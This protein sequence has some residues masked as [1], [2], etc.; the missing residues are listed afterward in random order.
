[1]KIYIVMIKGH[2]S[3][4]CGIPRHFKNKEKNIET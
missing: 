2:L 3:C 1:M 4:T